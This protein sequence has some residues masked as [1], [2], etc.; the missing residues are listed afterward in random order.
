MK[1]EKQRSNRQPEHPPTFEIAPDGLSI[2]CLCCG[3]RSYHPGDVAERYCGRCHAFHK[4][5]I[6]DIDRLAQGPLQT[7]ARKRTAT[8][9]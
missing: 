9:D 7:W 3:L 2:L 1:N 6:A 5:T 4:T 8:M